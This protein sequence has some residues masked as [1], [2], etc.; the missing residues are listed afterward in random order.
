M[1]TRH[2]HRHLELGRFWFALPVLGALI[3]L[4]LLTAWP[5]FFSQPLLPEQADPPAVES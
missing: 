1:Q 2:V 3:A 4:T 5:D